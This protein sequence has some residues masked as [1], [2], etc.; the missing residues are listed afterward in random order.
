MIGEMFKE[1]AAILGLPNA[2]KTH[3]IVC[4]HI[5]LR[6]YPMGKELVMR[7][8]WCHKD[9]TVWA[10]AQF[11]RSVIQKVKPTN[12]QHLENKLPRTHQKIEIYIT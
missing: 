5:L 4:A 6:C 10:Q 8:G 2:K 12:L 3:L 9:M 1:A 11:I 7:K